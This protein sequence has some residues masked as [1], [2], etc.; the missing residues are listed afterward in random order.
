MNTSQLPAAQEL[1]ISALSLLH[2][3]EGSRGRAQPLRPCGGRWSFVGIAASGHF[4]DLGSSEGRRLS[5]P[6]GERSAAGRGSRPGLS[7][8]AGA[9]PEEG[10]AGR[11]PLPGEAAPPG[12]PGSCRS[13]PPG[14]PYLAAGGGGSRGP[15]PR[16]LVRGSSGAAGGRAEVRG[17]GVAPRARPGQ[18]AAEQPRRRTLLSHRAGPGRSGPS[19]AQVSARGRRQGRDPGGGGQGTRSP[20]LPPPSSRPRIVRRPPTRP[21]RRCPGRP[22]A[23]AGSAHLQPRRST[24]SAR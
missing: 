2:P 15:A 10:G 12:P 21:R 18:R 20:Y 8:G 4:V 13:K 5:A 3:S 14:S 1:S 16:H 11:S 17:A 24:C 23:R 9:A 22:P 7:A 6:E 19:T